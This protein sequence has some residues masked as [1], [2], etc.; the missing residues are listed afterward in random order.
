MDVGG[1]AGQEDAAGAVAGGAA[2]VE[3]EVAHPDRVV[4]PQPVSISF[5]GAAYPQTFLLAD[6]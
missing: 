3:P 2:V 1:V 6:G 4:E 5:E